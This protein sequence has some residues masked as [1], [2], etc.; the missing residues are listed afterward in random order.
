V[1]RLTLEQAYPGIAF[2]WRSRNLWAR[3]TR[4]PPECVHLEHEGAWM[5]TFIPDT[6]F[7]RG[8]ASVRRHPPRPEVSLCRACL[9][10]ELE[11]DLSR[12]SGRII[13]FEPDAAD[14]TQYFFV[15]APEF[16]EAGLQPEVAAALTRR[17]DQPLGDC[18]LCPQPA[19]WLW[20]SRE[21]VPSLDEV[22]RIAMARGEALCARHG[23]A[24]LC[25]ALGGLGEANLFYVNVPYGETGAYLW[26]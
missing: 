5:A 2:R 20:I 9:L 18:D 24:K 22:G 11:N 10:G 21:Q 12:Y 25:E 23:A 15:G 14:F 17:L 13:A 19:R 6:L 7:L 16:S 4:V 26:I 8:K 3:I 1:A